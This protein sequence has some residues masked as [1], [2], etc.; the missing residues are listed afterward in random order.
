MA[1]GPVHPV[2]FSWPVGSLGHSTTLRWSLARALPPRSADPRP[3]PPPERVRVAARLSTQTGVSLALLPHVWHVSVIWDRFPEVLCLSLFSPSCSL[4]FFK[5]RRKFPPRI[6]RPQSFC[7][8]VLR[9]QA[10]LEL[11]LVPRPLPCK[12][13]A[14]EQPVNVLV[15]IP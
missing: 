5:L 2:S 8:L 4:S 6:Q 7:T 1:S 3:S 9:G 13:L 10:Q 14:A 12:Q 11:L 15:L